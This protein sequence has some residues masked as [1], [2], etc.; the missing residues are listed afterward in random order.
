MI[1]SKGKVWMDPVKVEGIVNWPVPTSRQDV[2][3][4]LGFC[5]FYRHFIKHFAHIAHPL[6]A[7]TGNAPFIWTKEC[8]QSFNELKEHITLA[9]VLTI[10]NDNDSFHLEIDTSEFAVGSIWSQRQEG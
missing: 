3:S 8:Q 5:N 10:P 4:F 6:H 1:V 2:Q 7:L 9:L